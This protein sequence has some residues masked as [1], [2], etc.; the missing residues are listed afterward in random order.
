MQQPSS[1]FRKEHAMEKSYLCP[2][3]WQHHES[4]N[5]LRREIQMMNENGIG[6]FIVEAR[7]HP[8]YLREEWWSDL[9][10]LIDEAEKRNMGVWIFDDGSYPSGTADGLIRKHYP[11]YTKKYLA[12]RYVDAIGP[13]KGSS[14]LIEPWLE[15]EEKLIAVVAGRRLDGL[16]LMDLESYMDVTE[17][18]EDG[19]LY[20]D[21]PEGEWRITILKQTE[22]GGEEWTKDYLNPLEPEGTQAFLDFVYEAHYEHFKEEF[23]KTIKGFFTDEPRFGSASNYHSHLGSREVIPWSDTLLDELSGGGLGDFKKLLPALFFESGE[24]TP[25][26]RFLYMDAVSRRFG[27]YFI[28]QI[29]DWCRAHKVRL[30]GHVIEENGAHARLGYGP[31]HY[32]RA[33]DGMDASGIDVVNN[34]YPGRTQGK[35]LTMFND[36]DTDFNHWGLSKMASSAAHLDEKKHGLAVCEAFGAYGWSEGLKTMKWITDAMCVRGINTIIPHAFSPKE[37]PDPDCPPHFYAGGNNPQFP[38]FHKWSS[39]ANRVCD[40]ISGGTHIAPAAVLYHAEAEWGGA[41]EPFEKVVKCLMQSQIDCDVV[42]ADILCDREKTEIRRGSFSVNGEIYETLIVPYAEYLPPVMEDSLKELAGAGIPVIFVKEYPKRFYLREEFVPE[43][44]MFCMKKE[45]L[46]SFLY[47]R[48]IW[49][50]HLSEP[51][52]Y[53]AYYHYRK[54]EKDFYFLVNEDIHR[55]VEAEITFKEERTAIWYDA[56]ENQRYRVKQGRTEGGRIVSVTLKPYESAFLVFGESDLEEVK[57]RT[58]WRQKV[59]CQ[60]LSG[61]GWDISMRSFGQGKAFEP[62]SMRTLE[63]LSAPNHFPRFSGTIRYEKSFQG[64]AG[65]AVLIS[66]GDVYEAAQ[67]FV[68][69]TLAGE[70]ICPPYQLEVDGKLIQDGENRLTVEVTNTLAKAYHDNVF[71]RFWVQEPSG[72]LGP[73]EIVEKDS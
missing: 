1:F 6:S 62:V 63:N 59:Q 56:M 13:M 41:Y 69:G 35:Y 28:G 14:V 33:M 8:H 25:D 52:E 49:D 27:T 5:A 43:E 18:V 66:L 38:L 42:P 50:I 36:Y 70:K 32:F 61:E 9:R 55:D 60:T 24:R 57:E 19:I 34:I 26:V 4:E 15:K 58:D 17:A 44:G 39:Y 67:V 10:I 48:G 64:K 11:Q 45:E 65:K 12:C 54:G 40:R 71:D 29:G 7:P 23:G 16:D 51:C 73:V 68:N 47:N 22:K 30:I 53:L 46:A 72:L 2:L 3:F 20:W 37:F 21:I 31:G